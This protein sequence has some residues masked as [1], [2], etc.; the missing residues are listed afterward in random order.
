MAALPEAIAALNGRIEDLARQNAALLAGQEALREQV[1]AMQ[2]HANL[3]GH[4]L[5]QVHAN[6]RPPRDLP[7]PLARLRDLVVS[8]GPS[9]AFLREMARAGVITSTG[10]VQD[11]SGAWHP[12]VRPLRAARHMARDFAGLMLGHRGVVYRVRPRHAPVGERPRVLH[13]IPNVFVGGSTQ[14]VV[15]LHERL[16]HRYEMQVVTA[17]LPPNGRHEGMV[18]HHLPLG[19]PATAF[20]ALLDAVKPDMVH[21]HYWGEGDRPWYEAALDAAKATS[22]VILENVNTPVEPL[23]DPRIHAYLFVSNY[24]R[25]TFA[26]GVGNGRV[27]HP[28]ID[29][30]RFRPPAAWA[31]GAA[32]T[33]GM[34][35]RLARDK[36]D[37]ASIEPLIEVAQRRPRTRVLVV[38]DG[39][40]LPVYFARVSAAGVRRNFEFTGV[41][42]FDQ[43]PQLY[44]QFRTFVAPVVRES[45]GQVTPFAMAM[46]QAVAGLRTGALPEILGGDE[47]LGA[48]GGALADILVGLLDQPER[49]AALSRANMERARR[50]SLDGMIRAYAQVYAE[51][52]GRE[53]DPMPGFPP[54]QFYPEV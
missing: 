52:L 43:L 24:I 8:P 37:D 41:V 45:F 25:V 23:R 11:A 9:L 34:V 7:L 32:D 42:P 53:A 30:D 33:I 16:G 20:A 44:R 4:I 39:E 18:L 19:T 13:V 15:D 3:V 46:G 5:Q 38:G 51:A 50:F 28:G 27:I 12:R 26:P 40:L 14:L 1:A 10:L 21:L 2:V 36:L 48:T 6:Q 17:A 49:M 54:A 35:Y 47:T 29:L 22:A 31:P